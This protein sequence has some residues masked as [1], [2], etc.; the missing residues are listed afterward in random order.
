MSCFFLM[1]RPTPRSTRTDT[2][3]PYTTLF[4]SLARR[5]LEADVEDAPQPRREIGALVVGG[6]VRLHFDAAIDDLTD[7]SR[8]LACRKLPFT[9]ELQDAAAQAR[10]Q[11]GLAP[12]HRG[13]DEDEPERLHHDKQ[14]PR[15]RLPAQEKRC[16]QSIAAERATRK[17]TLSV[18][19]E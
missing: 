19:H 6:V 14:H 18:G 8:E 2:L 1:I 13:S 16:G 11:A 15:R 17:E 7:A 9:A 10:D 5:D 4:R 12:H 3:F